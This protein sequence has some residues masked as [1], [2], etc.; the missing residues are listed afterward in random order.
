MYRVIRL[1]FWMA[2]LCAPG[3]GCATLAKKPPSP[4]AEISP[5]EAATLTARPGERY[6]ILVF[7][8]QSSPK[9]A[10][11]THTW[12]T[13]VR[14]TDRAELAEPTLEEQTISWMPATLEIRPLARH[15][16]KGVNLGLH[17][18]IQ[19]MLKHEERVAVWGP[20]EIGPGL[21]HRF[22][23]QKQFME[24]GQIGYQCIDSIGESARKGNGCDCIHAVTDMDPQFSRSQYPLMY[25]GESGSRHVV[26]ELH[27]RPIIIGPNH[28]HSWLF[29]KL[30]LCRYP[31][32]RRTYTGR[33]VENTP[34]SLNAVLQQSE[35]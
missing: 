23:V 28:D 29:A 33:T 7:G 14:V 20:Y 32:D 15:P 16:E 18:T 34:Q 30:E 24:S 19:E 21:Y 8:S 26:R 22:L 25:F 1:A 4:A 27:K 9:R 5:Q 12:A 10:K 13:V 6:Y 3:A 35:K 2:L 11:Y 31:L 17:F